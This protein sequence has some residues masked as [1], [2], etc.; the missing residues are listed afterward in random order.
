M[1]EALAPASAGAAEDPQQQQ[2]EG[3]EE[4]QQLPQHVVCAAPDTS[5]PSPQLN[6]MH[7]QQQQQQQGVEPLDSSETLQQQL[8]QLCSGIADLDGFSDLLVQ[9][10]HNS[11]QHTHPQPQEQQPCSTQHAGS[12]GAE[13]QDCRASSPGSQGNRS[14]SNSSNSEAVDELQQQLSALLAEKQRI[15][16]DRQ[17]MALQQGKYKGT[18]A[19]VCCTAAN[20]TQQQC[21]RRLGKPGRTVAATNK[22]CLLC[23]TCSWKAHSP[24]VNAR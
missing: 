7:T 16:A 17:D 18:I 24:S 12:S 3:H 2:Q 13:Q 22:L 15:E 1:A 23:C 20:Q 9:L 6:V 10:V 19:Q 14:T 21:A 4:Q 11:K 8:Q 5:Q